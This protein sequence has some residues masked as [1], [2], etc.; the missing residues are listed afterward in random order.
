MKKAQPVGT[1]TD[2]SM[3][4]PSYE[5]VKSNGSGHG[6][7]G[8]AI[9]KAM[10]FLAADSCAR[11]LDSHF[12]RKQFHVLKNWNFLTVEKYS[13]Y[14]LITPPFVTMLL[15]FHLEASA[16][17]DDYINRRLGAASRRVD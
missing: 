6:E 5:D 11:S 13:R 14:Q 9:T 10:H 15:L 1:L 7:F 4:P 17:E 12:H 2:M 8:S 16:W 3:P